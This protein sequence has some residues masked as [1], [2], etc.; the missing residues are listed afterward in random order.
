M[1]KQIN[2]KH[3]YDARE[4]VYNMEAVMKKTKKR[5]KE[6]RKRERQKKENMN[7]KKERKD[8]KEVKRKESFYS[9]LFF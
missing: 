9:I 4:S 7:K 6:R 3:C 5:R 1:L 2:N 8:K